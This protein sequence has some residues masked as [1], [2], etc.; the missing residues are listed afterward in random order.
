MQYQDY[1]RAT[2]RYAPS[3]SD[4]VRERLGWTEAV[5]A[6]APTTWT[7]DTD[8][9]YW[10]LALNDW[11]Y[12]FELQHWVLWSRIPLLTEATS[13]ANW[14]DVKRRG[15]TAYFGCEDPTVGAGGGLAGAGHELGAFVAERWPP[16][17]Y[18]G[19]IFVNPT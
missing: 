5:D 1:L 14:E 8:A 6:D 9:R 13:P 4:F 16:D 18:E 11:P 17:Q 12:A 3:I 15:L 19:L 10:T 2:K 7:Y